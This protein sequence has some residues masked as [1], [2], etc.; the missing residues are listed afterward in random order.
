MEIILFFLAYIS[1]FFCVSGWGVISIYLFS[2]KLENFSIS[3]I[4]GIIFLTFIS[5]FTSFF[6]KHGEIFNFS[7]LLIGAVIFLINKKKFKLDKIS[8][9]II[10]LISIALLISKNHDDFPFYHFQQS[11]NLSTN[12]FQIGLSNL[13]FSFAHHSSLLYL[14]SLFYLPY[15]KYYLFNSPNLIL[16]TS[17]V[18]YLFNQIKNIRVKNNIFIKSVDLV[19]LY[20]LCFTISYILLKFSRLSEYGTDLVGQCLIIIFFYLFIDREKIKSNFYLIHIIFLYC[21]TLKTYFLL[22]G[23]FYLYLIFVLGFKNYLNL[24]IKNKIVFIFS[25]CFLSLFFLINFFTTGCF[26]YPI[27]ITCFDNLLWSMGTEKVYEYQIW[28]EKWSKGIAGTGYILENSD[29]Y[30]DKFEWIG[31]WYNNYFKNKLL[32]NLV[33]W[34]FLTF[35]FLVVFYKKTK[36][37]Y[38]FSVN[39]LIIFIFI[40]C[41]IFFWFIKHP[42]LRYGGY[43][44]ITIFFSIFTSY[45][46]SCLRI[47]SLNLD[48]IKK[49]LNYIIAISL[50]IFVLKNIN[51]IHS[52]FKRNDEYK[53]INFP[54][55]YVPIV[56]YKEIFL[57]K[58]I[59]VNV[60]IGNNCWNT[61]PPCTTSIDKLRAK[62][63]YGYQ[64]FYKK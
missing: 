52:E 46:L 13:D 36:K 35:V 11:L 5:Y 24:L 54:Y 19:R 1:L 37:K 31:N 7:L 62:K 38:H 16:F 57:N 3:I 15:F 29:K 53:F 33:L 56:K 18:L 43:G 27:P 20:F 32:D 6:L 21:L 45:Y 8:F 39:L 12:K 49:K 9:L 64:V 10:L 63:I 34:F 28:Y 61:Q 47:N 55:F 58:D 30:L 50:L 4:L 17:I 42:T 26:I 40:N 48:K 22:Y 14:N 60:S 44:P 41:I 25:I 51:R 2:L 59:K 23:L